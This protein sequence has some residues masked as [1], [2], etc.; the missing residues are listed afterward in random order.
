[1]RLHARELV[2][3]STE[4]GGRACQSVTPLMEQES[5]ARITAGCS[6][7]LVT[8]TLPA[9]AHTNSIGSW[10]VEVWEYAELWTV[11]QV[12]DR[13][14]ELVADDSMDLLRP[15]FYTRDIVV[16]ECKVAH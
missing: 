12:E 13:I 14:R 3:R 9:G 11:Q 10:S 1:M 8:T 5:S 16:W 2:Q 4:P 6:V 15:R 7:A